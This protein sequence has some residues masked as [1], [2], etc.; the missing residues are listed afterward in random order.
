MTKTKRTEPVSLK[1]STKMKSKI[2]EY[3]DSQTRDLNQEI[4]RLLAE[5]L[6]HRESNVSEWI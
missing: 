5:A 3:A 4:I 6:A 1:L 2:Q